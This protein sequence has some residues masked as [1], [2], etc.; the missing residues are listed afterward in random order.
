MLFRP[1]WI[2]DRVGPLFSTSSYFLSLATL[3]GTEEPLPLF[4]ILVPSQP[5]TGP[6][7][8]KDLSLGRLQ[9]QERV[10]LFTVFL[11]RAHS[12]LPQEL[13]QNPR[14][15]YVLTSIKDIALSHFLATS[16]FYSFVTDWFLLTLIDLNIRALRLLPCLEQC[17]LCMN[18]TVIELRD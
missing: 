6:L 15:C 9:E 17:E 16:L 7:D 2:L 11:S 13:A 14:R 8:I 4:T 3:T 18:H 5:W 12:T 1:G 10:L